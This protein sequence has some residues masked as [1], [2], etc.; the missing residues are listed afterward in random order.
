M[1]KEEKAKL[2]TPCVFCSR[3]CEVHG[4]KGVEPCNTYYSL[5]EM[6]EWKDRQII[7]LLPNIITCVEQG[8]TQCATNDVIIKELTNLIKKTENYKE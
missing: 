7:E 1:T 3:I 8:L 4:I 6:A 5:I 2:L